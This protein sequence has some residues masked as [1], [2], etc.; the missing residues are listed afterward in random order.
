M[1]TSNATQLTR[2]PLQPGP[3]TRLGFGNR[4]ADSGADDRL[5][6]VLQITIPPQLQSIAMFTLGVFA[7]RITRGTEK[8]DE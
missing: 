1:I 7:N 2:H 8:H 6:S 3:L 5:L 4:D